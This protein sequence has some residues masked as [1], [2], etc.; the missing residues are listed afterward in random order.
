MPRV[1][2]VVFAVAVS[3]CESF[4]EVLG[5]IPYSATL[6]GVAVRPNPVPAEATGTLSAAL[7]QETRQW[8]Y[9]VAWQNL[10]SAPTSLH[11]H[12]PAD[13]ANIADILATLN[14]GDTD[15]APTSSATGSL[16]LTADVTPTV[17]GDSLR[18]L[19][20]AG[21]VYVDVHSTTNADGEIRGQLVRH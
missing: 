12:G 11:L 9:T 8:S 17:T 16:D 3:A 10:S 21:Q 20:N 18:Q 1:P 15:M 13:A 4:T 14:T 6:T 5:P 7:D 2:I 19:L